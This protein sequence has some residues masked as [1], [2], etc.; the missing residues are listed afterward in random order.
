MMSKDSETQL[1]GFLIYCRLT[2]GQG[3]FYPLLST[4]RDGLFYEIFSSM[5]AAD[6]RI[7]EELTNG[8]RS[9]TPEDFIV[10]C[11]W[12]DKD[13]GARFEFNANIEK[14]PTEVGDSE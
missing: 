11:L 10:K 5:D 3:K 13:E 7:M 12:W 14:H 8:E 4:R 2:P 1:A 9:Q 6:E